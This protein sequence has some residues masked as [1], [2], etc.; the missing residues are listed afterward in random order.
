M[1]VILLFKISFKSIAILVIST[2]R[3]FITEIS[4]NIINICALPIKLNMSQNKYVE[5]V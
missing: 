5:P 2:S 4:I 1:Q 3:S